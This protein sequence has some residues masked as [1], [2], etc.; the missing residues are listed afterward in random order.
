MTY[1]SEE[2]YI[3]AADKLCIGQASTGVD[4]RRGLPNSRLWNSADIPDSILDSI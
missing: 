4:R 1:G 3:N 2:N